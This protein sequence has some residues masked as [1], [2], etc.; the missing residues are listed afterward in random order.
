MTR[1]GYPGRGLIF[2]ILSFQF[3]FVYFHRVCPAVVAPELSKAFDVSGAALGLLSSGY[4]YTYAGMQ[5]PI[6]L[7][8]DSLGPRRTVAIF[9]LVAAL[10]AVFFGL[11]RDLGFALFSRLL[12]GFGVS[13]VFVCAMKTFA[14]FFRGQEYARVT[15]I[16]LAMGGIGWM[17]AATPLAAF[18]VAFGWRAVFFLT[19]I[20]SFCLAL[21]SWF[22][23]R[24][25]SKDTG[26]HPEA[27]TGRGPWRRMA[28]D[29][30]A[31]FGEKYFWPLAFWSFLNGGILFGFFGLWAGPYLFDVYHLSKT[32]AGNILAMIAVAMMVGS[33]ALGFVCDKV[34]P[35]R[36]VIFLASAAIQSTCWLLMLLFS[37]CIAGP[38]LY[39]L[40]FALG[41]TA[42]AVPVVL[43]TTTKELF[44]LR[45][46]GT[47]QGAMNL[48]PFFGAVVFQP[49]FGLILDLSARRAG[50]Y[51]PAAYTRLLAVVFG[52]T[53]V[54]L[55]SL[56]LMKE[57][58]R[59]AGWSGPP[60]REG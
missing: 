12:V 45:I 10:G 43:L 29:L 50:S 52:I 57:T 25:G 4:F 2:F 30:V 17:L 60:K 42:A 16:F 49:L 41:L 48:F 39:A 55:C 59:K 6:G 14:L 5:L 20:V 35:R 21:G 24:D 13:A 3:L 53:L 15:G 34:V 37:S 28:D 58:G 54:G 26:P 56:T 11:S 22:L 47:A 1:D 51:P 18:A 33:P 19:G 32:A 46:A 31:V 40:F 38:V 7:L 36:K 23:L 27:D 44:P 9:G 8:A